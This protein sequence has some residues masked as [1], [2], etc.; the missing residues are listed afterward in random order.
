M[1]SAKPNGIVLTV[2]GLALVCAAICM[3]V[4]LWDATNVRG[5]PYPL[6]A[7]GRIAVGAWVGFHGIRLLLKPGE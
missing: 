5:V 2:L 7:V 6:L 4:L 3:L 1:R